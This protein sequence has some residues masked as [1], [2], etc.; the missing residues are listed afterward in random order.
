MRS[1]LAEK[2]VQGSRWHPY[3]RDFVVCAHVSFP[4]NEQHWTRNNIILYRDP[5]FKQ[6]FSVRMHETERIFVRGRYHIL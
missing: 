6:I 1:V 5:V 4:A 3:R 2:C